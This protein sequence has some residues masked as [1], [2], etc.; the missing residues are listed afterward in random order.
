MKKNADISRR[1]VTVFLT[2]TPEDAEELARL[3]NDE[4]W[5]AEDLESAQKFLRCILMLM[6]DAKTEQLK[7]E[8][9]IGEAMKE[10][11]RA[12]KKK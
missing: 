10:K 9:T 7:I 12:K 2:L 3:L 5:Q 11:A 6:Q 4:P 8:K 1:N